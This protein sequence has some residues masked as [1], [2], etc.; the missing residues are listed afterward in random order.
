MSHPIISAIEDRQTINL[1]DPSHDI[2]EEQI[3]D[4]VRLATKAPTSFNLQNWRFIAVRSPEAKARLRAVG[5]DQPK[6]TDAAVTFIVCGQLAD[7]EHTPERLAPAVEAG[8]MPGEVANGWQGAAKNLYFEQP[9][10]SRDEAVRS[11]TFGANT[12]MFAAHALGMGAGPMS[13]FD[14]DGVA[15]EFDLAENEIPVMLLAIGFAAEGN[16]SQ[17]PRRPLSQV[18]QIV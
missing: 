17:K 16:W 6:I 7:H 15:R 3:S 1:F 13:G 14:P 4:L 11:A 12:L 5:W 18:L 9:Q 2:S 10:R 8:I